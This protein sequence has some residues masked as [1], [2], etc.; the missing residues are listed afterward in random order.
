[1]PRDRTSSGPTGSSPY[2]AADGGRGEERRPRIPAPGRAE[3]THRSPP[4]SS[5][6]RHDAT[7]LPA[8]TRRV[9]TGDRVTAARGEAGGGRAFDGPVETTAP[10]GPSVEGDDPPGAP[11]ER[12]QSFVSD[13]AAEEGIG[14]DGGPEGDGA[15]RSS[16][17]T[18]NDDLP[19]PPAEGGV[20]GGD[21]APHAAERTGDARGHKMWILNDG[22]KTVS[23]E[24][25]GRKMTA[26]ASQGR[27]LEG[28]CEEGIERDGE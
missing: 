8:V 6:P 9:K 3:P 4:P 16:R 5:S 11:D 15:L 1:M 21:E 13:G 24:R 23:G 12:H 17:E 10:I 27:I 19:P 22:D 2:A 25:G 7:G 18:R 26:D 20:L 14:V 28:R